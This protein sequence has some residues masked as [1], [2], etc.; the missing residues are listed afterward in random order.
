[1]PG[2]PIYMLNTLQGS[3]K[4]QNIQFVVKCYA[5]MLKDARK[6]CTLKELLKVLIEKIEFLYNLQK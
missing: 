1:M 5:K 4:Q 3:L 2:G 6:T